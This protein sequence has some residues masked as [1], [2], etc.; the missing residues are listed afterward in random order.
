[1]GPDCP[2][3]GCCRLARFGWSWVVAALTLAIIGI[4]VAIV[5]ASRDSDTGRTEQTGKAIVQEFARLKK[6]G[7]P[8]AEL[9]LGPAPVFPN[10]PISEQEAEQL[11]TDFCLHQPIQVV[12]VTAV[13][14]HRERFVLGTKGNVMTPTLSVRT[15]RGLS[16]G[17]RTMYNL[18]LLVEVRDGKIYGLAAAVP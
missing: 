9:L 7:D 10:G 11:Q 1:V 6:I 12:S 4:V 13:A 5:V 15:A 3:G 8:S 14:G 16:T 17:Q 18:D 2:A